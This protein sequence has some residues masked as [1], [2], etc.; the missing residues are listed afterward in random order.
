MET[1]FITKW[2]LTD[3]PAYKKNITIVR[4]AT[5]NFPVIGQST[6]VF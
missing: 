1:K 3:S 6:E 4:N 2:A 5:F